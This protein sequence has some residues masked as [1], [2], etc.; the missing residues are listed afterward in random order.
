MKDKAECRLSHAHTR[1]HMLTQCA[2]WNPDWNPVHSLVS[3]P[4]LFYCL[5]VVGGRGN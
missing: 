3:P 4:L 5:P 1:R 2:T